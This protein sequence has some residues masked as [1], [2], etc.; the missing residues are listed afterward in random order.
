MFETLAAPPVC[1]PLTEPGS[2]V[3]P[4]VCMPPSETPVY[5]LPAT[6]SS[7]PI[8]HGPPEE[9]VVRTLP[10]LPMVLIVSTRMMT[11]VPG[12]VQTLRIGVEQP[13]GDPRDLLIRPGVPDGRAYFLDGE[14]NCFK[15]I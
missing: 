6:P 13:E 2:P 12:T 5:G 14:I 3:E 7:I 9:P 10:G 15:H 8:V 1:V 11:A 4:P